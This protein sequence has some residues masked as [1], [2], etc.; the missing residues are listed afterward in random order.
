MFYQCVFMAKHIQGLHIT[1]WTMLRRVLE[2]T[3][4]NLQSPAIPTT[5]WGL[6]I[7]SGIP[8]ARHYNPRF[9]YF[10]PIF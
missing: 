5:Q 3:L 6:S 4:F 10:L 8:Y 7:F 2:P 9:V 1:T